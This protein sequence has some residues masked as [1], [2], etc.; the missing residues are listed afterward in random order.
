MPLLDGDAPQRGEQ[1]LRD[2]EARLEL[3]GGTAVEVTLVDEPP[4]VQHD[5]R[6]RAVLLEE[7]VQ[8]DARRGSRRR[9]GLMRRAVHGARRRTAREERELGAWPPPA[10]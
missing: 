3:V 10:L 8:P 4:A 2:R 6:A 9:R 1:R 5:E 7:L